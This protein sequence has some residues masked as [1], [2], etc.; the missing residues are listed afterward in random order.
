MSELARVDTTRTGTTQHVSLTG[1]L[2]LSNARAL[3]DALAH[4][5]PDDVT[6]VVLDLTGTTYVDS[7]A[8]ASLFRLSQRLRD[9]RQDLRLVVPSGSP[10]RA[11]VELT[12]LGQVIP[13]DESAPGLTD[14]PTTYAAFPP[15]G[16]A[17]QPPPTPPSVPTEP[18]STVVDDDG[19]QRSG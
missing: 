8:I 4:A 11:V 16:A 1:E 13:V 12:R 15:P 17:S 18:T 3:T 9:R 7:A 10:I 14:A 6:L 2:D 5:V 19:G